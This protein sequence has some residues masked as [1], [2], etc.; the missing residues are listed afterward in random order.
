VTEWAPITWSEDALGE[1]VVALARAA[2]LSP[3]TVAPPAVP[4]DAVDG[5][6]RVRHSFIESVAEYAGIEA[7]PVECTYG[8]L[9]HVLGSISPA[10]VRLRTANAHR[11]LAVLGSN[12][13]A[14][15]VLTPAL[16]RVR[17][18]PADVAGALTAEMERG[19]SQRVEAWL[20][21]A[22]VGPRRAVRARRELLGHFLSDRR[23]G[24]MWLLRADP[25]ASF[26]RQLRRRGAP[27]RAMAF[28]AASLAQVTASVVGWALIGRGALDGMVE[29]GWLMAW[30]LVA[31]SAV[32]LQFVTAWSGGNLATDVAALLK[33]RLLSGA[34]RLEPDAIRTR[35]SGHLLAMVSES[36]A[37]ETAGLTGALTAAVALVQ[38]ASAAAVLSLGAGGA[39]HVALLALWCAVIAAFAV[40]FHGARAQ[41]TAQRFALTNAFVENVVGNRTRIAQQSPQEW[42]LLE[43]GML[44]RYVALSRLMD[45]ANS[46]LFAL[47][48][49]GWL[50]VGFLGLV[51]AVL[52]GRADPTHLAIAVGGILQAQAAF[53]SLIGSA[54]AL[55][56]ALVAWRSVGHLFH[57]AAAIPAPG[58]PE[59]SLERPRKP[60]SSDSDLVLD[61]R[62]LSFRYRSGGHQVLRDCAM[63]L[64]EGDRVLLEGRSGGGKS[65]LASLLVGLHSPEAGHILLRGLDRPTLGSIGWR[66][67][68]ASAPQ[69]HENHVLSASLAFNLLMGRSWPPS[70]DDRREADA[71]CRQLGLGPMLDRMPSG[72]NQIVGETGWQLSHGERSRVFL[73][74]AL[75]QRSD[76]LVLD[77]TFGALDPLTLRGCVE[78]VLE[79][80]P[81]M[82]V[83]AHP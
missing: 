48:A 31:I 57:A 68:V 16:H 5:D 6:P 27:R 32:P 71:I 70:E 40:R 53:G 50:M 21:V 63:G 58:L 54:T 24:D 29:P 46:R 81:T 22:R 9:R 26:W 25:G 47:P 59:V 69:F 33:Q 75:L 1:V 45:A 34:L 39:L 61:V 13:R 41:W 65:T 4:K 76:L 64:R 52:A 74:R 56:G 35:G 14:L 3:T 72:L 11:Y 82:I 60:A 37:I 28:V 43:D 19:P 15:Q 42:H 67:R 20:S 18:E 80:A 36:E 73:A 49:R 83:I 8:E 7:E 79:R 44:D 10:L 62:G 38:L 77:E 55:I 30:A 23:V 78:T 2:G 17:V 12:E 51:P 66:R